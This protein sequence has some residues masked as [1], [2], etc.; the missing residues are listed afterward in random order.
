[1]QPIHLVFTSSECIWSTWSF[2]HWHQHLHGCNRKA[3]CQQLSN[4]LWWFCIPAVWTHTVGMLTV[5]G[6]SQSCQLRTA[7]SWSRERLYGLHS[8]SSWL[9]DHDILTA[10]ICLSI[11][12]LH[13]CSS[14]ASQQKDVHSTLSQHKAACC[15]AAMWKTESHFQLFLSHNHYGCSS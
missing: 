14:W 8:C 1:M 9:D 3:C 13:C 11:S 12:F 2:W 15:I 7:A 5:V 6:R 4:C 10:T